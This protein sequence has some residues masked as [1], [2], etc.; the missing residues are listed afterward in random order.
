[1]GTYPPLYGVGLLGDKWNVNIT[2]AP[3][4]L[5]LGLILLV[6]ASAQAVPNYAQFS[7]FATTG[8]VNDVAVGA[9]LPGPGADV[10]A[11]TSDG[12]QVF[13]GLRHSGFTWKGDPTDAR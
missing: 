10:P 9:L 3:I 4:A 2:A 5:L 1:M 8:N 13:G 7:Q 6:P 11:A 12:V